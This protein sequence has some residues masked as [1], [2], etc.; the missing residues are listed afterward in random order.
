LT[1]TIANPTKDAKT[2]KIQMMSQAEIDVRLSTFGDLFVIES[3][4]L[5][6]IASGGIKKLTYVEIGI[7]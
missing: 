2:K 5:I 1:T 6:K 4:M 7:I 3:R